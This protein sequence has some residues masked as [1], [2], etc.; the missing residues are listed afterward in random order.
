MPRVSA[1]K[2]D[3]SQLDPGVRQFVS[4]LRHYDFD[5]CDSGD[6][7][8]KLEKDPDA[9]DVLPWPHVFIRVEPHQLLGTAMRLRTVLKHHK[10]DLLPGDVQATYDPA[11]ESAVIQIIDDEDR[12]IRSFVLPS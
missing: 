10:I 11:D 8:T 6:G 12:F 5:T 4:M 2:I 1:P 9:E 7:H 3:L